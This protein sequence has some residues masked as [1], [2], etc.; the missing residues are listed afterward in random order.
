MLQWQDVA[1]NVICWA[2]WSHDH[3]SDMFGFVVMW[4]SVLYFGLCGHLIISVIGLALLLRDHQCAT[5]GIV[6]TRFSVI[7]L[8]L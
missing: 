5:L 3:Q 8:H 2:L 7:Y 6:V 4:L 1:I